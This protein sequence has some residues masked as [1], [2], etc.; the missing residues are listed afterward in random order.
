MN[1][2]H[3][4]AST[5]A[6]LLA[7]ISI[8][9]VNVCAVPAAAADGNE[10]DPKPK[11]VETVV[12]TGLAEQGYRQVKA[13]LGPLGD[14]ALLDTPF[15]VET[16]SA[17]LI[18][19][20]D[21]QTFP[22]LAKYIPSLQQQGHP[23]LEFGPPVIR[24]MAT[25]DSSANT[26]IDGMNV[27]GDTTLP[28]EL[29][30][31]FEVLTGP[32]GALYGMSYP[33]GTVNG[34]LKRP[35]DA[36]Y[37][38]ISAGYSEGSIAT[39]RTDFNGHADAGH[40]LGYR[41]N[42][43]Y[44][45]G[46]GYVDASHRNQKV[47]GVAL[48][49]TPFEGS[50]LILKGSTFYF[51]QRGFPGAF[52]YASKV[53]L[54]KAVDPTKVG[55]GQKF[56]GIVAKTDVFDAKFTQKLGADWMLTLGGLHQMAVRDFNARITNTLT[57]NTGAI[58]TTWSTSTGTN[59]VNSNIG[60]LQGTFETGLFRHEIVLGTN[61]YDL[62]SQSLTSSLSGTLGTST[63][64]S[65]TVYATPKFGTL[66]A[67]YKSGHTQEQT[68]IQA[69]TV[70]FGNWS[71]LAALSESWLW[72]K[73]FKS[74]GAVSSAY[75]KSAAVSETVAL[76]YKPTELSTVYLSYG[77]SLQQ[78]STAGTTVANANETLPPYRSYQYELG[79]K[80]A[81]DQIDLT[82]ALFYISRPYAAIDATDNAYKDIGRQ[83]NFGVELNARGKLTDEIAL[84]GGVTWLE[85]TLHNL[86][87][88]NYAASEGNTVMGTPKW[89]TNFLTEYSPSVV[90]GLTASVNLHYT[91]RR[92][93]SAENTSWADGYFTTDI[94]F[95]YTYPVLEQDVTLRFAV[96]NLFDEHYWISIN[97]NMDGQVGATNTA[98]L[99]TPRTWRV[100]LTKKF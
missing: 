8:I 1:K 39:V 33:G 46:D 14:K 64:T 89:R 9:V 91:G 75:R 28:V 86:E 88:T 3:R 96:D 100:A 80:L 12:V 26:R 31:S 94:G 71:V 20:E 48:S 10:A 24:G 37:E 98:Y 6:A 54:P 2:Y 85:A 21:I 15:T 56:G 18:R 36:P 72:T 62:T 92:P 4:Y 67:H 63:L 7:G 73:N 49:Y 99:G 93:A 5:R 34:V 66:G 16:L 76:S 55:Y 17:D 60:N 11:S 59:V 95:R 43:M 82:S 74:T 25:D 29:Y 87:N 90:P 52:S 13:N 40:K 81:L 61:G 23:A 70:S 42:L 45:D 65:P 51:G 77:N 68:L 19:N 69:D 58:K 22:D 50:E 30:D 79:Y 83:R 35:L 47:A 38:E 27:R 84:F 97:G 44:A 53:F 32:A 41:I 78:G 57:N